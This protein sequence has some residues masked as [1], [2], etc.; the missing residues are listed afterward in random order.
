MVRK[1]VRKTNRVQYTSQD[2]QNALQSVR[3]GEPL[4]RVANQFA[5]PPRTLRRHRDCGVAH[6]DLT[7]LGRYR[8]ELSQNMKKYLFNMFN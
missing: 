7:I 5:I 3:N 8:P 6:P 4:R 2:M 1:Y